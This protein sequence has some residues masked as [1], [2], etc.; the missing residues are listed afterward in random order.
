MPIASRS[1]CSSSLRH[2]SLQPHRSFLRNRND[3]SANASLFF[4][5][6]LPVVQEKSSQV[7]SPFFFLTSLPA[8]QHRLKCLLRTMV[9][10]RETMSKE[11][12]PRENSKWLLMEVWWSSL[13]P[14]S[15]GGCSPSWKPSIFIYARGH[16]SPVECLARP[17]PYPRL[18]CLAN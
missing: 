2:H 16:H 10:R 6:F 7:L 3:W 17:C 5:L 18:T 14:L 15:P 1:C 8:K 9:W 12:R 11:T 13:R 4:F